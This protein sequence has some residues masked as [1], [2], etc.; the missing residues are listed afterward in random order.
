ML[1]S[2]IEC[3]MRVG[4]E[5]FAKSGRQGHVRQ[6][7]SDPVPPRAEQPDGHRPGW[8]HSKTGHGRPAGHTDTAKGVD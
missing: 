8:I 2:S 3:G 1:L 4:M 7:L 5:L 6:A